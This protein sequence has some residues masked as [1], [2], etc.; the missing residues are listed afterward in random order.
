MLGDGHR[1]ESVAFVRDHRRDGRGGRNMA[2]K[3]VAPDF[4]AQSKRPLDVDVRADAEIAQVGLLPSLL[5][6]VEPYPPV[7]D[8]HR[9]QAGAVHGDRSPGLQALR[10]LA[11]VHGQ[12]GGAGTMG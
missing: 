8:L 2:R 5:D 11:E 6:D 4:V 7:G 3:D 1:H 12:R 9:G 10:M